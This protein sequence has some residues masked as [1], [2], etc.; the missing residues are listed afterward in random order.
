MTSDPSSLPQLN[1]ADRVDGELTLSRCDSTRSRL[2]ITH[3]AYG[4]YLLSESEKMGIV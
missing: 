1:A 2:L 3:T 4:M